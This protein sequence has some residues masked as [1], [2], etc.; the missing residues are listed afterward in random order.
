MVTE[1]DPICALQACMDGFR[2]VKLCETVRHADA[3]ITCTGN[4][5]IVTRAIMD[6]MKNGCIVCNMGH[7]N[8]EI[9][10]NSLRTP[11]LKWER[12]RSQV[13]HIIWPDGKRIILLAEGRLVNLS[14][15]T[16]PSFVIS[17]TAATQ[18]LALIELFNAPAGRY[19]QDV[20]LLPKK[21]DEYVASLHLPSFDARLTELTDEQAKYSGLSKAGPFKPNYYRY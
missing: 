12:I 15:S 9:D 16:I 21:M 6:R 4:K 3:V 1:I 19:K 18:A 8:T 7:S 14:C 11:D 10:V 2:V 5:N 13:D 20:Y 17:I